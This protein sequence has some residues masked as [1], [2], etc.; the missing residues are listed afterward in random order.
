MWTIIGL[1]AAG[2]VTGLIF[3]RTKWF[4]PVTDRL[5]TYSVYLLLF[6][7][8]LSVGLNPEIIENIANLGINALFIALLA[9]SGSVFLSWLIFKRKPRS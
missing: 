6:M 4:Y 3:T 7:M 8:G 2:T 9:T 5:M 1:F